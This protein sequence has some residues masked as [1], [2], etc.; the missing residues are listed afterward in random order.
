[1]IWDTS[2]VAVFYDRQ[3]AE[4][5]FCD[6][7]AFYAWALS[8]LD[9]APGSRLLDVACG[10]GTLLRCA[11]GRGLV[12]CGLDLSRVAIDLSRRSAPGAALAWGNGE[13]LPYADRAFDYVTCLGSLEHYLDPWKGAAQ[14]RRVLRPDGTAAIFLPNSYYLA[15]ILWHVLRKGRAPHHR[16]VIERF[17]TSREWATFLEMM[18]L[19]VARIHR[20]NFLFPRSRADWGWY[21]RYPLKFVNLVTGPLTPFHLSYSFLYLCEP[22]ELRPELNISLPLVLRRCEAGA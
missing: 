22:S 2:E 10:R 11:L 19:R 16:Q 21:R 17:A 3:F 5:G 6:S 12:T 8:R 13:A 9:P 1:M 7:D 15:D 18:G 4:Y 14:I 20:Y